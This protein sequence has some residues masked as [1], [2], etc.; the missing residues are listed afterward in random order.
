MS[1][2]GSL[3]GVRG[4]LLD[5][6]GTLL[7]G[8]RAI[9]GAGQA[10]RRLRES[11]RTVRFVTNTTRRPSSAVAAALVRAGIEA[12][13]GDVLIPASLARRRIMDSGRTRACM[14]VPEAA[15]EDLVPVEE[16]D[17]DADWVVVGDLGRAFDYDRLDA[18][19]RCLRSGAGLLALQRNR[20][21]DAGD[22][23]PRLDAGPFV[24]ALEYAAEVEAELLGKPA[25]AFFRLALAELGLP[26]AAVAMVGDSIE[27]D[28]EGA[29]AAGC[30]GILVRTGL[31]DRS[32]L[33][34]TG[35]T[36]DAVVD[37]V[38]DLLA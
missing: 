15:K 21:W 1:R 25:P 33:A 34:A 17:E 26:A 28:V 6:D 18:A 38:S 32:K 11:G 9:P 23:T 36:P 3:A 31:F 30:R 4:V 8:D 27:N 35:T 24:A 14:L 2:G 5:V 19:F 13:S 20:W 22:G 10:V 37:S 12:S 7:A 16:V 29:R